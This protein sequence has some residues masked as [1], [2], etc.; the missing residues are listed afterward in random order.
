MKCI[1]CGKNSPWKN[2]CEDC[3]SLMDLDDLE[4]NELEY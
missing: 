2:I 4:L 1:V 3:W